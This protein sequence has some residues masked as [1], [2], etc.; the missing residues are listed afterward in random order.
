MGHRA[1]IAY[2]R[3]DGDYNLHYSH[4]GACNLRLKHTLT[5]A[6]PFG[7]ECPTAEAHQAYDALV[8][9]EDV[10]TVLNEYGRLGSAD[11]D[12]EPRAV[13]ITL[14][15]AIGEWLDFLQHEAF[16]VVDPDFDVTA[17]RTLWFGLCYASEVVEESA[18]VGN[19]ALRTVRWY[20]GE[21]VGDG[22]TRGE[23]AGLKHVVAEMV[24]RGV[25]TPDGA[26]DYLEELVRGESCPHEE[27]RIARADC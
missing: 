16:F 17:Y 9:G 5:E 18:F 8:A 15:D 20:Q 7:G 23:F 13:G 11:V 25:F 24:D 21:P 14:D 19:G 26:L 2:E 6:T 10:H 4:W 22:Y 1:L 12:L 3:T 27:L